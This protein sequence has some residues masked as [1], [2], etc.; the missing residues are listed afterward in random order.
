MTRNS[1]LI[2]AEQLVVKKPRT[3][4]RDTGLDESENRFLRVKSWV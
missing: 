2:I 1:V 3:E 4:I